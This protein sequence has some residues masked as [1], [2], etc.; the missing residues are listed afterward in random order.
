VREQR[1]QERDERDEKS[2]FER[3]RC[4]RRGRDRS[5]ERESETERT[6]GDPIHGGSALMTDRKPDFRWFDGGL[7]AS[8]RPAV[9]G[10]FSGE[11]RGDFRPFQQGF[12]AV[13]GW[14]FQWVISG[15][16]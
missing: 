1:D 9:E 5:R 7:V 6:P 12:P 10:R 2:E 8:R 14:A 4:C 3:E 16:F 15:D 13:Q 11:T